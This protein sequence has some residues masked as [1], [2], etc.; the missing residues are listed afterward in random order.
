MADMNANGK[1][2]NNVNSISKS[3]S[4]ISLSDPTFMTFSIWDSDKFVIA[5][6]GIYAM[7]S[8][9][10]SSF[11]TSGAVNANEF[12]FGLWSFKEVGGNMV[13]SYNGTA[14]A[15]IQSSRTNSNL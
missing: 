3:G 11:N 2:I 9:E 5:D 8:I 15:T 1:N 4:K 10:A 13:I 14:K 12:K 7:T 6:N